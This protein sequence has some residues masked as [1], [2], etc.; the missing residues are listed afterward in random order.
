MSL[1][2]RDVA[3]VPESST[4]IKTTVDQATEH[5][6]VD[7]YIVQ[8]E[9]Q[10]EK[11][12]TAPLRGLSCIINGLSPA[13]EYMVQTEACLAPNS[14]PNPCSALKVGGKTWTNP[15]SKSLAVV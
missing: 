12:C 14:G 10:T 6:G 15:S 2:P 4:S 1:A 8:I 9:G 7:H 13:V 11:N 3:A 5:T